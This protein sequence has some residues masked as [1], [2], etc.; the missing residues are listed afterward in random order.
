M[1]NFANN[2]TLVADNKVSFCGLEYLITDTE[3]EQLRSILDGMVST[4]GI[5]GVSQSSKTPV[6]NTPSAPVKTKYVATKDFTAKYEIK[7][8]T[9][10]DGTQLFCISRANGWTRAEKSCM[11]KAIKALKNI[12]EIDVS[13]E[14]DGSTRTFK[15]WGY[16]T[17]ATAQKHL[18]ELPTV[19]TA[20]QLNGE[21]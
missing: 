13:Y 4:R 21:V 12:K 1:I 20:A 3:A 19:F 9:A 14:K 5:G 17:K 2:T 15:A 6:A 18:K 7:E 16:N 10:T 11:N 8:H